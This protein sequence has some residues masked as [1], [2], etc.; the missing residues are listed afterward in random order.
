M[1]ANLYRPERAPECTNGNGHRFSLYTQKAPG[2]R[3]QLIALITC[4]SRKSAELFFRERLRAPEN[5]IRP[6]R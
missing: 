3:Y 6:V 1:T 4:N 5:T 2:K